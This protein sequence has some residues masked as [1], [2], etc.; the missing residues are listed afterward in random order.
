MNNQLELLINGFTIIPATQTKID[1]YNLEK[2]VNSLIEKTLPTN[3]SGTAYFWGNEGAIVF[4]FLEKI[5]CAEFNEYF[6]HSPVFQRAWVR[7]SFSG[8]TGSGWH[9]DTNLGVIPQ[10]I[11]FAI[12]MQDIHEN[13]APLIFLPR[14][15][16]AKHPQFNTNHIDGQRTVLCKKGDVIAFL[17]SIWH[18]GDANTSTK[19]RLFVF[20]EYSTQDF[21]KTS[22]DIK[23]YQ[24]DYVKLIV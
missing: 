6:N 20:A 19:D 24:K 17:S 1:M 23:K 22:L 4:E 18:R 3:D 21:V 8:Y 5:I 7:K 13:N 9:Q 11:I 10:P 12:A 2:K 16:H 15:Q 14:S